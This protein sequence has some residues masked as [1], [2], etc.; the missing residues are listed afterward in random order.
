MTATSGGTA[1]QTTSTRRNSAHM[2]NMHDFRKKL[3][4][5]A[6]LRHHQQQQQQQHHPTHHH[7]HAL[8]HPHHANAMS[9]FQQQAAN[10]RPPPHLMNNW[11]LLNPSN[12]SN[13]RV[14][15]GPQLPP[16]LMHGSGGAAGAG[17]I[18]GSGANGNRHSNLPP[19]HLNRNAA[20]FGSVAVMAPRFNVPPPP[21][22]ANLPSQ[23]QQQQQQHPQQ[24]QQQQQH[25]NNTSNA[26]SPFDF[27]NQKLLMN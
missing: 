6:A 12:F 20:L 10:I 13:G 14:G 22:H 25:Y 11:N 8:Q 17:G 1:K 9:I 2:L 16:P 3:N 24:Q 18:I 27:Y 21:M 23:Q 19:S 7:H 4:V 15:G 5:A 26:T